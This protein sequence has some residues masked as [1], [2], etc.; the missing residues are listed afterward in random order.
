MALSAAF[1]HDPNDH[2]TDFSY[3]TN[4]AKDRHL[5]GYNLYDALADASVPR[6]IVLCL[7]R[8]KRFPMFASTVQAGVRVG[9]RIS[10]LESLVSTGMH[11][12]AHPSPASKIRT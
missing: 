8:I 5:A 9:D 7:G 1:P 3:V 4:C 11:E 12:F 6:Y 2:W 10:K